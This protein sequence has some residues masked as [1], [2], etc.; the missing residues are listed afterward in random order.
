MNVDFEV[1]RIKTEISDK[2]ATIPEGF[3]VPIKDKKTRRQRLEELDDDLTYT[4]TQLDREVTSKAQIRLILQTFKDRLFTEI[5]PGRKVVPK[6]LIFAK[7][8]THAE[9]ITTMIRDV[10]GEGNDFA[11]K[12][13]YTAK[14]PEN[15]LQEFRTSP[16][17]R[18]AVTVD[19]IATGTDVKPIECVFFMRDVQSRTYFEQMKGRGARTMNDTDFQTVTSDAKHKE[20]F[21]IIDAVGVTEHPFTDAKPLE[22]KKS[23]SLEQLFE[24]A[25]NFVITE[26]ETAT[27]ASRLARLER[28]LTPQERQEISLLAGCP[29]TGITKQ[30]MTV[31]DDDVLLGIEES[32]AKT[33]DGKPDPKAL[34]VAMREYLK[35]IVTPLAGNAPLRKRLLEIRTSHDLVIDEVSKDILLGAGGV[36][37]YDKC[38]EVITSWKKFLEENKNEITLLQLL[39]SQ[40]KNAKITFKELRE[41]A[42]RLAAPQPSLTVDLIWNAYHALEVDK[43]KRADKHTAT[44]L[45]KLVRYTLE[46]DKELVPY[47]M[48]VEEKYTNWLAQQAQKGVRFTETQRWWLDRIKD[49]IIQSAHMKVD[50]L[51]LAPF[52]ERGGIDGASRDLGADAKS[53]IDSLNF[54][55][56]A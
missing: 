39:Y 33:S 47:A 17:L 13:T 12:I 40:P 44:D 41:L 21:V 7:D 20:R 55:L 50:D 6:T 19:M 45:I 52:T 28:E 23:V 38:R 16:T 9:E 24:R 46:V 37:D 36:I 56:A 1:Y 10:F 18:V 15:L 35:K 53:L 5:F 48:T 26:D 49:T 29:L 51:A 43:V 31:A 4:P 42:D 27:L 2:G 22:R 25:A 54:A 34:N 11:T 3:V 8:D 32:V 14:N 30:L